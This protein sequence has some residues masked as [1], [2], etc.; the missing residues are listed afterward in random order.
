MIDSSRGAF[1]GPPRP[2]DG[3][4]R[5][6]R[7]RLVHRLV[8]RRRAGHRPR[9]P[10]HR[11][12]ARPSRPGVEFVQGSVSDQRPGADS[13]WRATRSCSTW[14]RATSSRRREPAR[15]LR[16]Q[17][18]RHAQRAAR[19]RAS[20]RSTAW[21]TPRPP[22]STAT[23]ARSRST[24]TTTSSPLTPY[25]VSKLAGENYCLAFYES[26]GLPDGR[27][28]LLQRLRPRA[29]ARQPVLRRGREVPRVLPRGPAAARSTAT[30]SRPATSP[31]STTRS[32][33][34]CWRRSIRAPRARCSTSGTGI[35]TS[36]N[37][38]ARARSADAIGPR[39]SRPSTSTAATSTT[40]GAAS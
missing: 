21:S 24:R 14:R 11:P 1:G 39:R 35:E 10:V 4:R 26:Y 28:P 15:R 29:A 8:E 27:G 37:R 20:R 30:A 31:T 32:T 16:D 17:H 6:R 3:R 12:G 33:P 40:S 7:R 18:R 5:L 23:R 36:V 22:R 34:R 13:S 2:R 19:G 38:L 9:R 25:A